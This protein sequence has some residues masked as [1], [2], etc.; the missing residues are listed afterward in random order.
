[1]SSGSTT[2]LGPGQQHT[3]SA[4]GSRDTPEASPQSHSAGEEREQS[5]SQLNNNHILMWIIH[6][7]LFTNV[8]MHHAQIPSRTSLCEWIYTY[9]WF[10]KH[11]QV[12]FLSIS[13][14]FWYL[15]IETLNLSF[16]VIKSQEHNPF[17]VRF[18]CTRNVLGHF[19][20]QLGFLRTV[21]GSLWSSFMHLGDHWWQHMSTTLPLKICKYT[22]GEA[23]III[24]RFHKLIRISVPRPLN[25]KG[26]V[27]SLKLVYESKMWMH[28]MIEVKLKC[29]VMWLS[30]HILLGGG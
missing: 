23:L 8:Y 12:Y 13:R 28:L 11:F 4:P 5:H 9:K 30:T 7:T 1:M 29:T 6:A 25:F 19:V 24:Q 14:V 27:I 18:V 3:P 2:R 17:I 26:T 10:V 21:V 22:G 15:C 20:N 16:P